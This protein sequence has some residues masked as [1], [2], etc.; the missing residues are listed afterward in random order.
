[1]A[2]HPLHG[3][4][5]SSRYL[6]YGGPSNAERAV[7]PNQVQPPHASTSNKTNL[8]EITE[9]TKQVTA[10]NPALPMSEVRAASTQAI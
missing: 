5:S 3:T 6:D 8:M 1:M 7:L 2:E 4:T 10:Q 9:D